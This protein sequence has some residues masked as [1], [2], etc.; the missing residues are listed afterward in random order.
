MLK[1]KIISL[2]LGV[3]LLV[4][5]APSQNVMQTAIAETL[6]A[7]STPTPIVTLTPTATINPCTDRGWSDITIYLKQFDQEQ[8]NMVVGSSAFAYLQTLTNTKNKA[9]I[10]VIDA[11]TEHARQQIISYMENSIYVMQ[12][13]INGGSQQ[14]YL[15]AMVSSVQALQDARTELLT[16]GITLDYP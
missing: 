12:V 3:S 9:N 14:D 15:S 4:A 8:K 16:L 11:C 1:N 7:I 5:C 13:I 6:T 2:L 10:V